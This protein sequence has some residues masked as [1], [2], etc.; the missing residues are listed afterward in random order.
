MSPHN[1]GQSVNTIRG[2]DRYLLLE[3]YVSCNYTMWVEWEILVTLQQLVRALT[4]DLQMV[5]YIVHY[6]SNVTTFYAVTSMS[7]NFWST[8][9]P[10]TLEPV[11]VRCSVT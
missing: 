2:N 9:R 6:E 4:T 1:N 10:K 8:D 5:K 3:Q 7:I 11:S